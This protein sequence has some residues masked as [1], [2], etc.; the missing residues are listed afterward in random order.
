MERKKVTLPHLR[1]MKMR[2]EKIAMV[3]AYDYPTALLADRAGMDMLLVGDSLAMVVLGYEGTVPVT[4]EEMLHHTK[5]VMRARPAA[6]VVA[7][8][9]FLSYQV[10]REEAIRNAGRFLKEGGADA[11]K[12]EGGGAMVP[13][14]RAVV[15]AGIPVMGHL[16]LT[17]QTAS[18]LGGFR[19]QGKG[20]EAAERIMADAKALEEAGA[21]SLV[22]E[23]VPSALAAEITAQLKIPVIGIGAGPHCDGQVLVFHDLVG[24]FDR[25]LPKFVKRYA[26]L[27]EEIV[28]A[29]SQYCQE[30]RTGVFPGEEHS[31]K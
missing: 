31:F 20:A 1:E 6:F 25:F 3:T 28:A 4:M 22:L 7:D 17:P 15:E 5:A 11:V 23:C 8:L 12:L 30:V 27:S 24:L 26:N 19:V 13:I 9:P 21:F 2:G 14:V 16:G 10:G 18:L 29:L